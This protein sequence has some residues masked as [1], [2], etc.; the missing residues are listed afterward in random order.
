MTVTK[1]IT[2]RVVG[3]ETKKPA[4][5]SKVL[6]L[7]PSDYKNLINHPTIN[8]VEVSGNLVSKELN[9]LSSKPADYKSL[10]NGVDNEDEDEK[11]LI[12]L[13]EDGTPLK[14]AVKTMAK[15]LST[16]KTTDEIDESMGIGEYRFIEKKRGS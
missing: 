1:T 3:S 10:E 7:L 12:I 13:G 6:S 4:Q 2:V 5:V 14:V 11:Y 9:L 8:G 15:N 16:I